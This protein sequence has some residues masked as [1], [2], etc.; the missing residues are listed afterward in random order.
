ME[1]VEEETSRGESVRPKE[2]RSG[3]E[4]DGDP[5]AF[6]RPSEQLLS[7]M[8]DNCRLLERST[9]PNQCR[10]SFLLAVK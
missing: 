5:G 2:A 3:A 1:G 8:G 10:D 6:W 7:S 4:R 9:A